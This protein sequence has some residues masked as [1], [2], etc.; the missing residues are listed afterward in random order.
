M[1][2]I[3]YIIQHVFSFLILDKRTKKIYTLL[4]LIV[5][6]LVYFIKVDHYDIPHYISLAQNPFAFE[7]I[8]FSYLLSFF[9]FFTNSS[10][11]VIRFAQFLIAACFLL[12]GYFA[13]QSDSANQKIETSKKEPLIYLML[14]IIMSVAFTL[15]VNN[16][17]RQALSGVLAL[18]LLF[19]II[20]KKPISAALLFLPVI[21]IHGSGAYFLALIVALY[22][23]LKLFYFNQ[24]TKTKLSLSLI[25]GCI[26]FFGIISGLILAE[27]IE[28]SEVYAQYSNKV[29]LASGNERLSL[30][31]KL[32]PVLCI[33]AVSEI[34]GGKYSATNIHLTTIRF[35][36]ALFLS[37]IVTLAFFNGLDELGARMLYYYFLIEMASIVFFWLNQSR[38]AAIFIIF[39]YTF[40]I[41]AIHVLSGKLFG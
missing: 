35:L 36:R 24:Y 7:D 21:F 20:E 34:F 14:L 6:C 15:G 29:L 37:L 33:Y 1:I 40:A 10:E 22:I 18:Y 39:S 32:I 5:F 28:L 38:F 3:L 9:Y 4:S 16:G 13:S 19:F 26:C 25:I 41:N 2:T 12:Y 8:G 30:P 11:M 31:F 23:F 27:F 17:L